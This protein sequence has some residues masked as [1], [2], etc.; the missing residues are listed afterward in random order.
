MQ[1][2]LSSLVPRLNNNYLVN[3]IKPNP[4]LYGPFWISITL[5]FTIAITGNIVSF[6]Q[7]LGQPYIW[8]T[9][10]HKGIVSIL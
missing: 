10:F 4:D 9:D 6:F 1:R 5:I 3:E 7:N 2:I 8:T